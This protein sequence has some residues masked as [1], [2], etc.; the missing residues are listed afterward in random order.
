M[1]DVVEDISS[2]FYYYLEIKSYCFS[3]NIWKV[4][5]LQAA[6][7]MGN[8]SMLVLNKAT[9]IALASLADFAALNARVSEK[10]MNIRCETSWKI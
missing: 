7:T 8:L 6:L 2:S 4:Y 1:S 9:V 10:E 5:T 3:C